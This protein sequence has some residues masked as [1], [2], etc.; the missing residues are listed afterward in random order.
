MFYG[1]WKHSTEP[2]TETSLNNPHFTNSLAILSEFPRQRLDDELRVVELL[3]IQ[4][5][6]RTLAGKRTQRELVVRDVLEMGV[7]NNVITAT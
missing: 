7:C 2:N 6:P 3:A 4:R 1:K 5:H